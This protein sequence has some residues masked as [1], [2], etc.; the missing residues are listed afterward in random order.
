[1]PYRVR[2]DPLAMRQIDE[3]TA[4]LRDYN[5][6]FALEQI[7]RTGLAKWRSI[8]HY[9]GNPIRRGQVIDNLEMGKIAEKVRRTKLA[10]HQATKINMEQKRCAKCSGRGT[11]VCA[12]CEYLPAARAGANYGWISPLNKTRHAQ[13][14]TQPGRRKRKSAKSSAARWMG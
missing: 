9:S 12:L 6:D 7:D 8:L 10:Q 2:I 14:P 4:Y 1:M 5:E 11:I 3:F 13:A